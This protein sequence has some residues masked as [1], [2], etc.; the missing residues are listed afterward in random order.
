MSILLSTIVKGSDASA[1]PAFTDNRDFKRWQ[2][3]YAGMHPSHPASEIGNVTQSSR[4]VEGVAKNRMK[5]TDTFTVPTGV[6][7]VRITVIGGGGGGG[8]NSG[9]YYASSGGGGGGCSSAEYNV[10]AGD[11]L[12]ITCGT[13]GPGGYPS[14]GTMQG[15]NGGT[16]SVSASSGSGGTGAISIT[17]Y[18]GTG[19]NA[20]NGSSSAGGQ[21]PPISGSQLVSGTDRQYDGGT[22][23]PGS[24]QAIG[25]GPEG[26]SAG[27]GGGAGTPIDKGGGGGTGN[28]HYGYSW[29][30]GGGGGAGAD[31]DSNGGYGAGSRT[32]SAYYT[33]AGGGGGTLRSG[34]GVGTGGKDNDSNPSKTSCRGGH[35]YWENSK[36]AGYTRQ[37]TQVQDSSWGIRLDY[38]IHSGYPQGSSTGWKEFGHM[39]GARY[40]DGENADHGAVASDPVNSGVTWNTKFS[41]FGIGTNPNNP[42]GPGFE[43]GKDTTVTGVS[44]MSAKNFNGVLG[45]MQGG[46]GAPGCSK[47]Q[48]GSGGC[49]AGGPGGCGGGGGG[50]GGYTTTGQ[51]SSWRYVHATQVWSS[52]DLAF[53]PRFDEDHTDFQQYVSQSGQGGPGGAFGG[54]G[55]SG[56]YGAAGSGGIGGGGG[57]CGGHCSG[58]SYNGSGGDG[59]PGYVLIEW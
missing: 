12:D 17:A 3:W 53:R 28:G 38:P 25:W 30:S 15:I 29:C 24:A 59:G 31:G 4:T 26:Y 6:S 7:K 35:G 34:D 2:D 10:S 54:G 43:A 40:G 47:D 39:A 8:R 49:S 32:A 1:A 37:W 20:N 46:G 51:G 42:T 27:G 57:G 18:G 13:G 44:S 19:G 56:F 14:G 9:P 33:W 11:V 36:I 55:G 5:Y 50:S 48:S 52:V 16:T 41:Q 22:G 23:G 45:R 21:C 58:G